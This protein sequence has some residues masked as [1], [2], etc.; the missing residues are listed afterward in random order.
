[1]AKQPIKKIPSVRESVTPAVAE[2]LASDQK[3]TTPARV[4]SNQQTVDHDRFKLDNSEMTKNVALSGGAPEFRQV[5]HSHWFHTVDSNG[6]KQSSSTA[7]G[8][9]FHPIIVEK[10]D[11][12]TPVVKCGPASRYVLKKQYGKMVKV[13][14]PIL[15]DGQS[16]PKVYDEHTHEIVYDGSDKI[17]VRQTNT[18]F[19]KFDS[20]I[21]AR[22]EP[23]VEGVTGK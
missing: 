19:A 14:A 17:N 18:E 3:P 6:R 15:L 22:R 13:I 7:T 16:D 9:H 11:G 20:A 23:T 4:Y 10:G 21:R 2:S 12:E 5:L 8:G 1:M